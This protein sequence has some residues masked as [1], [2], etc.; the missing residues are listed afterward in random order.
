MPCGALR[1]GFCLAGVFGRGLAVVA[2]PLT[3]FFE[4]LVFMAEIRLLFFLR[5]C[6]DGRN[7]LAIFFETLL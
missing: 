5:P 7:P 3:I 2:R 1:V 4:R 6:Y